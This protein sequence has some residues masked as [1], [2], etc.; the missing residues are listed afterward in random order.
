MSW[1][2]RNCGIWSLARRKDRCERTLLSN[3]RAKRERAWRMHRLRGAQAAGHRGSSKPSPRTQYALASISRRNTTDYVA[4]SVDWMPLL[5][6][7]FYRPVVSASNLAFAG[8]SQSFRHLEARIKGH[9]T[10]RLANIVDHFTYR[11]AGTKT[12]KMEILEKGKPVARLG[13]KATG[14]RGVSRVTWEAFWRSYLNT[15]LGLP[16]LEL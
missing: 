14:L 2:S 15:T 12:S 8:N 10:M 16:T 7:S 13:R 4:F 11:F 6:V 9:S 3:L 5:K 1:R